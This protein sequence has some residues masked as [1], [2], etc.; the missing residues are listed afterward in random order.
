MKLG[1]RHA[2]RG[3]GLWRH[4]KETAISQPRTVAWGQMPPHGLTRALPCWHLI[5]EGCLPEPWDREFLLVTPPSSPSRLTQA[6][7]PCVNDNSLEANTRWD[8]K[9]WSPSSPFLTR[10]GDVTVLSKMPFLGL[11]LRKTFWRRWYL[12]VCTCVCAQFSATLMMHSA[13]SPEVELKRCTVSSEGRCAEPVPF[14][15][16]SDTCH[17][18]LLKD[19]RD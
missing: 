18:P 12:C 13:W 17:L 10:T 11:V 5:S 1:H 6:F 4:R 14:L 8:P 16:H 15:P 7:K 19:P 3:T 2:Q 9:G